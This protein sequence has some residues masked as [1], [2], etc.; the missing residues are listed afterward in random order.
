MVHGIHDCTRARQFSYEPRLFT[1]LG[2]RM[3]DAVTRFV[4]TDHLDKGEA[5]HR[6][7]F[8]STSEALLII[9]V[10]TQRIVDSNTHAAR[11]FGWPPGQLLGA[12][13]EQL[14]P[15]FQPDGQ[16]SDVRITEILAEAS[17]GMARAFEW[18]HRMADDQLV[19]CGI[20]LVALPN[21]ERLLVR[22]SIRVLP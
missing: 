4:Y 21:P 13:L 5:R 2:V 12:E 22:S 17:S 6:A 8:R 16:R 7:L 18:T 1:R 11:V 20:N 15:E 9:D 19:R 3:A 10:G 14:N